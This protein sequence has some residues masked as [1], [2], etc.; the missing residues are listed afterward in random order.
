MDQN[1]NFQTRQP[2]ESV[3]VSGLPR[4]PPRLAVLGDLDSRM[5]EK[6]RIRPAPTP[7]PITSKSLIPTNLLCLPL[8][9]LD[10]G[11]VS[12]FFSNQVSEV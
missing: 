12:A 10:L 5:S 1:A 3:R 2:S 11:N 8:P 9:Y 6:T 7:A 4:I